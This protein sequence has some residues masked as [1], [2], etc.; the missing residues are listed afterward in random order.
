MHEKGRQGGLQ[1]RPEEFKNRL[2]IGDPI[3]GR[4]IT[5]QIA[6]KIETLSDE[7]QVLP[8]WKYWRQAAL[9]NLQVQQA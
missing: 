4:S 2:E 7:S 1:P 9:P 3:D 8:G 6:Q 5:A